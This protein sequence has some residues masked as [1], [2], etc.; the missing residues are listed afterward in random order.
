MDPI[1]FAAIC[2][3]MSGI[4]GFTVGGAF[5]NSVWRL[6]L[7]NKARTLDE[8]NHTI[9]LIFNSFASLEINGL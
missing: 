7:R 2:G 4:V 6:I 3:V 8:V 5:F 1:A 9:N